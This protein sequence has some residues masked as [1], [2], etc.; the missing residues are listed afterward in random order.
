M[1]TAPPPSWRVAQLAT[2]PMLSVLDRDQL[3]KIASAGGERTFHAGETI[4]RQG[5]RCL[6]LYLLLGG[7]ADVRRSGQKVTTLS[8]GKFFGEAALLADEPHTTEVFAT[9][10][11]TCFVL[12]RW[13]FWSAVGIDPQA[14]RAL[15]DQTVQR[16][17]ASQSRA[18]E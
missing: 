16:L 14:D 4:V 2:V 3:E 5:E 11:V 18:I 9:A 13:N 1:A 6:G 10:E 7:S 17:R 12:N 15:F 8:P